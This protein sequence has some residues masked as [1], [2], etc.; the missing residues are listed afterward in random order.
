MHIGGLLKMLLLHRSITE[1]T[2]YTGLSHTNQLVDLVFQLAVDW[3]H[4]LQH[5]CN[6]K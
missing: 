4:L 2:N 6:S 5:L 1:L 3:P